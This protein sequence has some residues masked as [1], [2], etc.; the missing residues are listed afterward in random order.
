MFGGLTPAIDAHVGSLLPALTIMEGDTSMSYSSAETTFFPHP[1]RINPPP[2]ENVTAAPLGRLSDHTKLSE[3]SGGVAGVGL[4]SV[5]TRSLRSA[6]LSVTRLTPRAH[7]PGIAESLAFENT[8]IVNLH[9]CD[10]VGGQFWLE[11]KCVSTDPISAGSICIAHLEQE[12]AYRLPAC[13][14]ILQIYLPTMA[15]DE[16][17][18]KHGAPRINALAQH[19]HI[20][21]P[22]LHQLGRLLLPVLETAR[23]AES[24]FAEHIVLAAY[25]H[26]ARAYGT[27][28]EAARQVGVRLA[29]WQ[30][31]LAKDM[32]TGDLTVEPSLAMI[33][34][35]CRLPLSRFIRAFRASVGAPPYTWLREQ[36]IHKARDLLV[37]STMSL[38]QIAYDCGFAD[39]SHF[40]RVFAATVGATPGAWRRA[41]RG[42]FA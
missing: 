6:Q 21:D 34:R 19:H 26:I 22:T 24:R 41:R 23:P 7:A 10:L 33:A 37:S 1:R 38:A 36:R 31:R 35:S 12:P 13:F 25:A 11:G 15:F 4:P 17:N 32:L 28:H 8:Y 42:H 18:E 2:F 30:E 16:L 14:D 27:L 5:K 3:V 39:Q 9:L 29:P 20:A 40:T